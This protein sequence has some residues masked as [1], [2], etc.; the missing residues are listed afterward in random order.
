MRRQDFVTN[1][2]KAAIEGKLR[3]HS[4]DRKVVAQRDDFFNMLNKNEG[5]GMFV[6]STMLKRLPD[7]LEPSRT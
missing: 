1:V 2:Q 4:T 3:I 6:A 7:N 5:F